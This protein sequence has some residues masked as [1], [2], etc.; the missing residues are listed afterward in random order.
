MHRRHINNG[1]VLASASD[2]RRKIL[3]DLGYAFDI[4]VPDV[5]EVLCPND[6]LLSAKENAVRKNEWCRQRMPDRTIIS[7]DTIIEF[8]GRS[9]AKPVSLDDAYSFLRAFSGRTHQVLTAT[10]FSAPARDPETIVVTSS[11]TFKTL[12]DHVIAEYCSKVDTLDKAG[13]YNI[14]EHEELIVESFDGSYT[15]IMGLPS[16]TVRDWLEQAYGQDKRQ[17]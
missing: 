9:I 5:E 7:A 11:V 3:A 8:E 1:L 17:A 13:A 10:T 12:S 16:E 15:N 4:V 14:D 6:P 2:R